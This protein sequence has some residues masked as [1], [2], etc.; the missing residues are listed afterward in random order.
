MLHREYR[1][2]RHQRQQWDVGFPEDARRPV[3][4]QI[5]QA[6]QRAPMSQRQAEHRPRTPG[7]H[8]WVTGEGLFAAGVHNQKRFSGVH[9]VVQTHAPGPCCQVSQRLGVAGRIG[10]HAPSRTHSA[11]KAN[12]SAA[13]ARESVTARVASV[14]S[15]I[16][17]VKRVSRTFRS[18]LQGKC[19]AGGLQEKVLIDVVQL[20]YGG[21]ATNRQSRLYRG[22]Q[23]R[24]SDRAIARRRVPFVRPSPA[25]RSDD[26]DRVIR[27]S[28]RRTSSI[29]PSCNSISPNDSLVLALRASGNPEPDTTG[30]HARTGIL[31]YPHVPGPSPFGL[32]NGV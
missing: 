32:Y 28:R 26:T 2:C 6:D 27:L 3:A 31:L 8:V 5:E 9:R 29:S 19:L 17:V 12:C 30:Y 23:L 7:A 4:L 16:V 20:F 24:A 13:R 15:R 10:S 25:H 14:C 1:L 11:S 21:D 18:C 22:R